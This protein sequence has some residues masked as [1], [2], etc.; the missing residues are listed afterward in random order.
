MEKGMRL[1]GERVINQEDLCGAG[2]GLALEG[3]KREGLG[4]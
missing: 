4:R 3:L 2:L 1:E